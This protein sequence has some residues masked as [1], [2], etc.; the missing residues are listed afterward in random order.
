MDIMDSVLTDT[1]K[2]YAKVGK[3]SRKSGKGKKGRKSGG[4]ADEGGEG[5]SIVSENAEMVSDVC[6]LTEDEPAEFNVYLPKEMRVYA[7][8]YDKSNIMIYM[9][10]NKLMPGGKHAI[11]WHGSKTG[12]KKVAPDKYT[13]EISIGAYRKEFTV[14]VKK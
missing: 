2:N 3:K 11:K 10:K 12:K 9:I 4:I 6:N 13:V 8:V 5:S 14:T 7:R 1:P